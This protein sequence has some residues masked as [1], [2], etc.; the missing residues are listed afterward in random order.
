VEFIDRDS[1]SD[2]EREEEVDQR[3]MVAIDP[4]T[5]D[6]DDAARVLEALCATIGGS[7]AQLEGAA[8]RLGSASGMPDP[9]NAGAVMAAYRRERQHSTTRCWRWLSAVARKAGDAG[10]P[11]L[12]AM[13]YMWSGW[14]IGSGF[15]AWASGGNHIAIGID[16]APESEILA[17][18]D[19]G[20]AAMRDL[21]D[22]LILAETMTEPVSVAMARSHLENLI[23]LRDSVG[24][25]K[26]REEIRDSHG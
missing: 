20:Q 7:L 8:R 23:E 5:I 11:E 13:A 16:R 22:D 4:A 9:D 17:I 21:P 18:I 25:Q 3:E 12:A 2:T 15:E 1:S 19:S 14:W 10:R 26:Y 24:I 6:L